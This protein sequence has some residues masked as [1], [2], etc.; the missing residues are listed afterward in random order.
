MIKIRLFADEKMSLGKSIPLELLGDGKVIGTAVTNAHG[1]VSFDADISCVK[2]LAIRID[3][4]RL[5]EMEAAS[6]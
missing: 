6:V 2:R 3:Q 1:V 4:K 5:E